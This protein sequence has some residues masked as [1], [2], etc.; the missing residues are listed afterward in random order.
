MILQDF[1]LIYSLQLATMCLNPAKRVP[2]KVRPHH[3]NDSRNEDSSPVPTRKPVVDSPTENKIT[4]PPL[5]PKSQRRASSNIMQKI[6]SLNAAVERSRT[7]TKSFQ[8]E[9][10]NRAMKEKEE[11]SK[12]GINDEIIDN[13]MNENTSQ[14]EEEEEEEKM[15]KTIK[16]AEDDKEAEAKDEEESKEKTDEVSVEEDKTM[17][18]EEKEQD[19]AI[20]EDS[21]NEN[22]IEMLNEDK[23]NVEAEET[24][25]EETKEEETEETKE[26]EKSEVAAEE[27]KD[28]EDESLEVPTLVD[29]VVNGGSEELSSSV[30]PM[31]EPKV[32]HTYILRSKSICAIVKKY[33][34]LF[35]TLNI[36]IENICLQKMQN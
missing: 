24:K 19:T 34:I 5:T 21:A 30:D 17:E 1:L 10:D 9:R 14:N 27:K 2:L 23:E 32:K 7:P 29:E 26:E 31:R 13:K 4:D 12:E 3:L 25:E 18:Q 15:D 6:E 20:T 28:K 16:D 36:Y 33:F 35:D 11:V 22:S 8:D